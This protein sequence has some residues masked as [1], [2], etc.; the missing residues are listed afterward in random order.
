MWL[1]ELR[2]ILCPNGLLI[3]TIMDEHLISLWQEGKRERFWFAKRLNL[4]EVVKHEF[5]IVRGDNW[6]NS[7]T[8]FNTEY[9]R[10]EWGRYLKVL[11][12]EPYAEGDV[13]SAVIMRKSEN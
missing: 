10:R 11:K 13:Q 3:L 6:A 1:M 12:I 2:R 5:T 4:D 9:I 7:Y 8:L